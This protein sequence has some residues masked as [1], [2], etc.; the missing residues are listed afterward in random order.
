MEEEQKQIENNQE[1]NNVNK[2]SYKKIGIVLGIILFVII[3]FIGLCDGDKVDYKIVSSSYSGNVAT[4]I[5]EIENKRDEYCSYTLSID[6]YDRYGDIVGYEYYTVKLDPLEKY[7]FTIPITCITSNLSG[8]R[9]SI[10]V[11]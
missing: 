1:S 4:V 8:G 6:V 5:V 2:S 3:I 7:E 9:V 11:S 10:D